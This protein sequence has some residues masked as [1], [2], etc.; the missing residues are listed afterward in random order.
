MRFAFG[1]DTG[2]TDAVFLGSIEEKPVG[3]FAALV[4]SGDLNCLFGLHDFESHFRIEIASRLVAPVD[5]LAGKVQISSCEA[6][7]RNCGRCEHDQCDRDKHMKDAPR[8]RVLLRLRFNRSY[9]IACDDGPIVSSFGTDA[10]TQNGRIQS[11]GKGLGSRGMVGRMVGR[12]RDFRRG[13]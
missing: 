9:L 11:G 7:V 10:S 13:T 4:G 6:G 3:C 1:G 2:G 5:K 12:T 8:Q